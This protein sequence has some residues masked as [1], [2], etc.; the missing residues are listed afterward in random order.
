MHRAYWRLGMITVLLGMLPA[1]L[2]ARRA[3]RLPDAVAQQ[4]IDQYQAEAK[5][6]RSEGRFVDCLIAASNGQEMV[7]AYH[8]IMDDLTFETSFGVVDDC[9]KL[10]G[11]TEGAVQAL[12]LRLATLSAE[13]GEQDPRTL[14]ALRAL[15]AISL[16]EGKHGDTGQ[17]LSLYMERVAAKFGEGD[18]RYPAMLLYLDGAS[19]GLPANGDADSRVLA[20]FSVDRVRRAVRLQKRIFGPNHRIVADDLVHLA[21]RVRD[22]LAVH[23]VMRSDQRPR[24]ERLARRAQVDAY[25]AQRRA[26]GSRDPFVLGY[27]FDLSQGEEPTKRLKLLEQIVAEAAAGLGASHPL[28]LTAELELARIRADGHWETQRE[29]LKAIA[30][31]AAS[32]QDAGSSFGLLLLGGL[33][34]EFE[35]LDIERKKGELAQ[36]TMEIDRLY[37]ALGRM[38]AA[39]G[40][41]VDIHR[42]VDQLDHRI[43]NPELQAGAPVLARQLFDEL[44]AE[45]SFQGEVAGEGSS[46]R[47]GGVDQ[48]Y[49]TIARA[50]WENRND[51]AQSNPYIDLAFAALQDSIDGPASA[52]LA[53][54]A[55]RRAAQQVS[56][57]LPQLVDRREYLRAEIPRLNKDIATAA[58][59]DSGAGLF[60]GGKAA[61]AQLV[62]AHHELEAV[63]AQLRRD[64]PS[65]FSFIQPKPLSIADTQAL[66]SADEALLLLVPGPKGSFVIAID[67]QG[68]DWV[69]ASHAKPGL[70]RSVQRLLWDL[71]A[72]VRLNP[73]V[74]QRWLAEEGDKVLFSR[75]V[76]WRLY[77]ELIEPVSARLSHKRHLFVVQGGLLSSLPLGVLVTREP[78]GDDA[79]AVALRGTGWFADDHVL[80]IL[81][82]VQSLA[83]IRGKPSSRSSPGAQPRRFVGIGDPVLEGKA[84]TRGVVRSAPS[85]IDM[86]QLRTLARL[87][88]TA[89]ELADMSHLFGEKASR[90]LLAES[91]NETQVKALPLEKVALLAFATHGVL[92]GEIAGAAEPGLVLTPPV[93]PSEADDGYLSAPEIAAMRI[94]ADWVILS[95]C[96]TAGGSDGAPGLSGLARSFLYAGARSLL[97]SHRPVRDDVASRLTVDMLR[98]QWAV[99]GGDNAE[100]L[101][102]AMLAIRNDTSQDGQ[103]TTFA[104]PNAWAPFS[105]VGDVA[106]INITDGILP[107]KP[108]SGSRR[109]AKARSLS[110]SRG[111]H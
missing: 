81:P 103:P 68:Y 65:Y 77:R 49:F 86:A 62:A 59:R 80:S 40:E 5:I 104:H 70:E 4:R 45:R 67:K 39:R 110:R 90:L 111:I 61:A 83:L 9:E 7:Q 21:Q 72:P 105:L 19:L 11:G 64:F 14:Q 95:A 92:A 24:L 89:R 93:V 41:R 79:D 101:H 91:A 94:D 82:S 55:A 38:A 57:S 51:P 56:D 2:P 102:A 88:G 25:E 48:R 69:F 12:E 46:E 6:A 17:W 13:A 74:E 27:A 97:V 43:D 16:H 73:K 30:A 78:T 71:R 98:R 37:D 8:G 10:A 60:G 34:E 99:G 32:A 54:S 1:S 76:A 50:G 42:L 22:Q 107:Q 100:A 75:K 44:S 63:N 109:Q 20:A 84:L 66:L 29:A 18:P 35:K 52:A 28:T 87:P 23:A 53:R 36:W 47:I 58:G 26:R 96:N 108:V 31:K 33:L 106:L 3:E 15:G 85:K